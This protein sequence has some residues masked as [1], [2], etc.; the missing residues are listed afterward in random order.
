[1]IEVEPTPDVN[2]FG[3]E[4][5]NIGVRAKFIF[6]PLVIPS[7]GFIKVRMER[8]GELHLIGK[9][10]VKAQVISSNE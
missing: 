6:A 7:P 4:H 5:P 10:A 8:Q 3:S 1:V 9:L 2:L